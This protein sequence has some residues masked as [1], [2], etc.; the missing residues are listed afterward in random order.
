MEH[1]AWAREEK[2]MTQE[3]LASE[4]DVHRSR[5]S[6]IENRYVE[7]SEE[8]ARKIA[9]CVGYEVEDLI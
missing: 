1:L 7:P 4:L 8:E 5:I 3:D 6:K 9:E 2:N